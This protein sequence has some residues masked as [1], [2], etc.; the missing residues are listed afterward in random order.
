PTAITQ[1]ATIHG[2]GTLVVV[3]SRGRHAGWQARA[4][5][6][7]GFYVSRFLHAHDG[8]KRLQMSRQGCADLTES[9]HRV[10]F[11]NRQSV[12][13]TNESCRYCACRSLVGTNSF[14]KGSAAAP[15]NT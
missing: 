6:I 15:K 10:Q 5:C 8:D 13:L 7:S 4:I 11:D 1:Q 2:S 12:R 3:V 14:A 9:A